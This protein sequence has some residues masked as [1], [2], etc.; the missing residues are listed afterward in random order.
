MRISGQTFST[1]IIE[2]IRKTLDT[3]VET[4]R[5][6]LSRRVCEWLDWR[7]VSGKL[8]AVE[9]Y[10]IELGAARLS[11]KRTVWALTD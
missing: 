2:R 5:S 9:R 7:S 4:T 8:R 1:D 10:S 3:G 6:G 11:T